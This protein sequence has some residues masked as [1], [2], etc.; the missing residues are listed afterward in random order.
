VVP[1]FACVRFTMV[2]ILIYLRC[3]AAGGQLQSSTT[4]LFPSLPSRS[5][6]GS[7]YAW[8]SLWIVPSNAT[9]TTG[10][11]FNATSSSSW[12]P[13]A[14]VSMVAVLHAIK[15][16][17]A[18][19]PVAVRPTLMPSPAMRT[20]TLPL[21][22]FAPATLTT[23]AFVTYFNVT[24]QDSANLWLFNS[25][26][27]QVGCSITWDF[28][29]NTTTLNATVVSSTA[30][31]CHF[32]SW[33]FRPLGGFLSVTLDGGM[34]YSASMR[35]QC[36]NQLS[37]LSVTPGVLDPFDLTPPT[38]SIITTTPIPSPANYSNFTNTSGSAYSSRY[39]LEALF[40]SP[41]YCDFPDVGIRTPA[42]MRF[43][44]LD[45]VQVK[46]VKGT[47]SYRLSRN[48][49]CVGYHCCCVS[50]V[51]LSYINE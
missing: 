29:G 11:V 18:H 26:P 33:A 38:I 34:T 49:I 21:M 1:S 4:C 3:L 39:Q 46:G 50:Y 20:A 15:L 32:P 23:G 36:I 25:H 8:L 6:W 43:A 35:I 51:C 5:A 40:S 37:I 30:L 45:A 10:V 41:L 2:C 14:K 28:D 16:V 24:F 42:V 31:A 13:S 44:E 27:G 22:P 48:C 12:V 19:Y 17:D 47:Q 7:P 9:V